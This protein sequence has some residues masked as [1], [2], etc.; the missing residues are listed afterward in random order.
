MLQCPVAAN[1]ATP[2]ANRCQGCSV[3]Q[4]GFALTNR[5]CTACTGG[6]APGVCTAYSSA[7]TSCVCT[8]CAAG[9]RLDKGTCVKCTSNPNCKDFKASSCD[10]DTCN[11]GFRGLTC[12]AVGATLVMPRWAHLP[13]ICAVPP[14]HVL[15]VRRFGNVPPICLQSLNIWH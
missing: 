2:M 3:C 15:S 10:C 9:W 8:A 7:G 11:I 1:C 12:A 6:Q 4:S 14:L 13:Y 5:Q